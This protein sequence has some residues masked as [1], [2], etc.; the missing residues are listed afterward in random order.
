MNLFRNTSIVDVNAARYEEKQPFTGVDQAVP[1][2]RGGTALMTALS[3]CTGPF[4]YHQFGL[5]VHVSTHV[6]VFVSADGHTQTKAS[7]HSCLFA[8]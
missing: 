2:A 6:V 4:I 5:V 3:N 7:N 1:V 8:T